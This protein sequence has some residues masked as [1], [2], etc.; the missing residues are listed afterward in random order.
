MIM[1]SLPVWVV[2]FLLGFLFGVGSTVALL[3]WLLRGAETQ[4]SNWS[5]DI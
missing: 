1:H 3:I 4:E 5:T 2:S